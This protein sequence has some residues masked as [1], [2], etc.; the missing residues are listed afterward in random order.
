MKSS[1]VFSGK[2]SANQKAWKIIN[3][4]YHLVITKMERDNISRADLARD[5]GK[6]RA[7]ISQ[8]FNKTPNISIKK[9]I[10]IAEAI[11]LD[12]NLTSDLFLEEKQVRK[13]AEYVYIPQ[14]ID[15]KINVQN[16]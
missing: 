8:M 14:I 12:I 7:A 4:F 11:G 16:K 15:S 9:M 5:L 13:V 6:S 2:P 1:D 10:E 3:Q